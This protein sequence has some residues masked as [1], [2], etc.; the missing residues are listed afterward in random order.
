MIIISRWRGL[1]P[2]PAGYKI[3]LS[4]YGSKFQINMKGKNIL[5][6]LFYTLFFSCF[7]VTAYC[8]K[9][10][11]V[12]PVNTQ[13]ISL[14]SITEIAISFNE[15]N[16]SVLQGTT[17]KLII[18]E[19][20]NSDNKKFFAKIADSSNKLSI[21]RGF[22]LSWRLFRIVHS[23]IEIYIPATYEN[24]VGIRTTNG[25][26]AY[27]LAENTEDISLT[28]TSGSITLD[29][30][31]NIAANFSIKTV[32]GNL[33]AP[34]SEKLTDKKSQQLVTGEGNPNKNIILKTISGNI[35]ITPAGAGL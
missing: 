19:Y 6:K 13:E 18:K 28:T 20:R 15:E 21:K 35:N 29:L 10:W 31:K 26:I 9:N 5:Q 33:A 34:F 24:A 4:L 7:I 27:T 8:Q 25:N 32:S 14:D 2:A 30:P 11:K 22:W 16:V 3:K 1:V 12:E 23:R 17:G